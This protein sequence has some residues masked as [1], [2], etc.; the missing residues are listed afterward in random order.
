MHNAAKTF[1]FPTGKA[2]TII[3]THICYCFSKTKTISH[4]R[5][6][7]DI[8]LYFISMTTLNIVK[9]IEQ[10]PITR[11]S[12][13]YHGK[14]I[15][16]IK[17]KFIN[18]E[19]QLF[20]ASFYSYL[21]YNPEDFVINLDDIWKWLGFSQKVNAKM[22][23]EKSFSLD[24]DYKRL[25]LLQ[26][27]QKINDKSV[28][29]GHNKET[30]MLTIKAFKSFCLKA[31]TKKADQIHEYYLKLEETLHEV[32]NE[33]SS[34][35]RNQVEHLKNEM[36]TNEAKAKE[37]FSQVLI[38]EK[39][40]EKQKLLLREFGNAGA[41]VYIVRV[42]SYENGC[43]VVKIGESRRGV[44]ARFNEHKSKYEEATLLD[45]F[46][47]KR[48]RDF[49]NF[50][51][52][53]KDIKLS[54]VTDLPNHEQE[55]ELFLI[56]NQLSYAV[57]LNIIRMNI[58]Q[59]NENIDSDIEKIRVENETLKNILSLQ[60]QPTNSITT[61]QNNDLLLQLLETNKMLLETNNILVSKVTNLE[62]SVKEI[63]E[64]QNSAQSRTTT[65]FEQ[66]LSTIGPR[67]QKI[68]PDTF[69]LIKVYET[70]TECMR[71]DSKYKRPS[72]H[73]AIQE[74][75]VYNGFRWAYVDRELDPQTVTIQPTKIT[76]SQNLGYI[77]KLNASK[78]EIIDVYLDRKTA[79][80]LNNYTSTSAL[81]LPVKN[82]S[83]TNGHYYMLYDKCAA[84][85]KEDFITKNGGDPILYKDG[86]GQFDQKQILMREFVC[87]YDCI[88]TLN[89]SD[90]T[91]AK[92]LKNNQPYNGYYYKS[93][94]TKLHCI[95]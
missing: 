42:K 95:T 20:V 72:L 71:E 33:E 70:V 89:M 31:G 35:L 52:S 83:I 16:K 32:V 85:L 11:L 1:A 13:T 93:I 94:G 58:K 36:V 62:K 56:G 84:N 68:Q 45:C 87:K 21:N 86:V 29:G 30:F 66:P 47:V 57:L 40:L 15:T 41:L 24:K 46:M 43:Y 82:G 76:K 14:L 67:L 55:R 19:Q 81:D 90:K 61:P 10:N 3:N 18:E 69:Q 27:K 2:N 59:F 8:T 22:L 26:Q 4:Q 54:N 25:L 78:T 12:D 9:L 92:A 49:E 37:E 51:H 5:I 65:N 17:N 7:K 74:N 88:R 75:T 53:H 28:R 48:S 63:L 23:L 60:T 77:A 91:L 50:L 64:K 6:Q 80:S 34:E 73:K 38:K 79:A 39:T 44:E